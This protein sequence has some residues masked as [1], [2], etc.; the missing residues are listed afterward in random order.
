[1]HG[2]LQPLR[3]EVAD[4]KAENDYLKHLVEDIRN[5]TG[6]QIEKRVLGLRAENLK[7]K[8]L[9]GEIRKCDHAVRPHVCLEN[10]R[11]WA[12]DLKGD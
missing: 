6:C 7:L 9:L 3:D 5:A 12:A 11:C 10:H 4:V 8:S 1:M 2:D